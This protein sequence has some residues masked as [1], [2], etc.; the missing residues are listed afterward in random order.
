[1]QKAP[2]EEVRR[3]WKSEPEEKVFQPGEVICMRARGRL[4]WD[5]PGLLVVLELNPCK[6]ENRVD[7]V[8]EVI[9]TSTAVAT[10]LSK[11][12]TIQKHQLS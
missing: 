5:Q 10:S 12:A 7:I 4:T 9:S 8:P 11:S 6:G 2:E 1:M 3:F